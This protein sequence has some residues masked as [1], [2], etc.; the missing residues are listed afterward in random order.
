MKKTHL[1]TTPSGKRVYLENYSIDYPRFT[2]ADH[3]Y[4]AVLHLANT[5]GR[6]DHGQ[7]AA[8]RTRGR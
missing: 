2:K 6:D 1:G 3:A 7:R 4:A 8:A 5:H